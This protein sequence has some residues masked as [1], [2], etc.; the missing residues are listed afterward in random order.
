MVSF[1]C[2][3]IV[4]MMLKERQ[5]EEAEDTSFTPSMPYVTLTLTSV[6]RTDASK[7][8]GTDGICSCFTIKNLS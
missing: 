3:D 5:R 6:S 8:K 1:Y 7:D 2:L 4:N